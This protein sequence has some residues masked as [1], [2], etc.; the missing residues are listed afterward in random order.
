M[1]RPGRFTPGKVTRYLLYRRLGSLQGRSGQV[2]KISPPPGLDPRTVHP[3]ASRYTDSAIP[4][5]EQ[6]VYRAK[7]NFCN[8]RHSRM[9]QDTSQT[10]KIFARRI[11]CHAL[12]PHLVL[13]HS[14]NVLRHAWSTSSIPS[15]VSTVEQEVS[16][17]STCGCSLPTCC[18]YNQ[19][20]SII[21]AVERLTLT[22]YSARTGTFPFHILDPHCHSRNAHSLAHDRFLCMQLCKGLWRQNVVSI[23]PFDTTVCV[24]RV[25]VCVFSF[26]KN[27]LWAR[28][29]C[30]V[31]FSVKFRT[32]I[33]GDIALSPLCCLTK[34]PCKDV[35]ILCEL[36]SVKHKF[37]F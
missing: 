5:H 6:Y 32:C 4:A 27:H 22:R 31:Q 16:T 37:W 11:L 3:V 1:P 34:W 30:Q 19:W 20:S 15:C 21:A 7:C 13:R 17:S 24:V 2:R 26:Y 29:G 25:T 23:T 8:T 18:M 33:V 12:N 10:I 28:N 36:L 14:N 35:V 9:R